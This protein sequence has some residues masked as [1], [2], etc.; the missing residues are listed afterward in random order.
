MGGQGLSA[1]LSCWWVHS[2][3]FPYVLELLLFFHYSLFAW[4]PQAIDALR[5]EETFLNVGDE[6][7]VDLFLIHMYASDFVCVL[8]I[9]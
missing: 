1:L 4:A 2:R 3:F 6:L 7:S 9:H 5:Y 8:I